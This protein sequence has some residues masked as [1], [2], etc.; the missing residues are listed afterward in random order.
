MNACFVNEK[1]E[2][3]DFLLREMYWYIAYIILILFGVLL[4]C[5]IVEIRIA[6]GVDWGI[7]QYIKEYRDKATDSSYQYKYMKYSMI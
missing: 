3:I 4:F 5:F 2:K 1:I 7:L 6:Y